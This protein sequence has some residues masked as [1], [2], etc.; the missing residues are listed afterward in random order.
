MGWD[1][2]RLEHGVKV[3][4]AAAGGGALQGDAR[5]GVARDRR[6]AIVKVRGLVPAVAG[7]HRRLPPHL[8][9]DHPLRRHRL[10]ALAD[11]A[12]HAKVKPAQVDPD[13]S[14]P[15]GWSDV[16][17]LDEA[18]DELIEV[19][20]FLRD[21]KR[22]ERL[23]AR[24]PRHPPLRAAGHRQDPDRQGGRVRVGANFYSSSASAFV[25]MF[26]GL[27]AARIRKLFEARK[28]APAIVFI[29]RLDAVGMARQG[30]GLNQGTTRL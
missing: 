13:L 18:K 16:A 3:P 24:V 25:G 23:G 8:A 5:T 30:H 10:P 15:I 29:D 7:R 22:F 14:A 9:T 12:V 6:L 28:N 26:A 21:R 2:E 19:V 17:G 4:P 27:G 11:D 1:R 20:E